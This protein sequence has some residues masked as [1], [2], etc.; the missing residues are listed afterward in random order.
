[1]LTQDQKDHLT[2]LMNDCPIPK[3]KRVLEEGLP[4]FISDEISPTQ[5]TLGINFMKTA[6]VSQYNE[7]CLLGSAM[8]GKNS[9]EDFSFGLNEMGSLTRA[10]DGR[11]FN[12]NFHDKEIYDYVSKVRKVI[13][14]C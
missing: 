10:F 2:Q 13:F 5:G 9:S 14:G 1:M 4:R 11:E 7:C 8:I 3:L 6:Y 12:H